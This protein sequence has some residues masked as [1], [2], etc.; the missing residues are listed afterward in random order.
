[1]G[2]NEQGGQTETAAS[3]RQRAD[4]A[5]RLAWN[6]SQAGDQEN[7]LRFADELDLGLPNWSNRRW[8]LRRMRCPRRPRD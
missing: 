7:I 8:K 3:L 6:L 5:R 1:M 2:N 4:R